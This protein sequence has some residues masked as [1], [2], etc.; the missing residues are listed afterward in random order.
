MLLAL[1]LTIGMSGLVFSSGFAI[2]EHGTK[3]LGMANAFTAK[4][5]DASAVWFNPAGITQLEGT[6][7]YVGAT[8][9]A[10]QASY[11]SNLAPLAVETDNDL[12]IPPHFYMTQQITDNI[13]FGIGVNAPF[14]LAQKWGTA[15]ATNPLGYHTSYAKLQMIHISPVIAV[16][17]SE[18]FSIG[19]G[20]HY[21]LANIQWERYIDIDSLVAAI[22]GG[23]VTDVDN[24]F[25]K[26]DVD[27]DDMTFYG[28]IR[29]QISPKVAFGATYHSGMDFEF[30]G[31]I[32]FQEPT[33][34]IPAIDGTLALLFPDSPDQGGVASLP[35]V[36]Q[37]MA[38][39]LFDLGKLELELDINYTMWSKYESLTLDFDLN[40]DIG[41]IPVV[42][43]E[44][45]EKNWEDTVCIRLGG[46]Y[47]VNENMDLRFGALYDTNPVP[48]ATLD[49]M[50]PDNDRIGLTVGFGYHKNGFVID[51][52]YMLLLLDE[53]IVGMNGVLPI[54]QNY[55]ATAAHLFGLSIGFNF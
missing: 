4:A 45:I 14:G 44:D 37:F 2:Y 50:L 7:F 8:A 3:A 26:A 29:W 20:I 1:M 55:E 17:V 46:N 28:G 34:N 54:D 42:A 22:S 11:Y 35:I 51:A 43:D 49:P 27:A 18:N 48:D 9:I 53:R 36:D 16:K 32:E 12:D 47:M 19:G 25:F 10:H 23:L 33:T 30:T 52:G 39:I 13:W 38:G 5:D 31:D 15:S 21:I 24:V 41:G 6:H 40:T